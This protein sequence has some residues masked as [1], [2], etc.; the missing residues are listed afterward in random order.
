MTK[1]DVLHIMAAALLDMCP[2]EREIYVWGLIKASGLSKSDAEELCN[3]L[4]G[5]ICE[6]HCN[7]RAFVRAVKGG[8][9]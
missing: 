9:E 1:D 7:V 3:E 2:E 8:R 5:A 6:R 4:H